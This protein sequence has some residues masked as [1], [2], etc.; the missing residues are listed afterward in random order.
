[1]A[2][3]HLFAAHPEHVVV[4]RHRCLHIRRDALV[5]GRSARLVRTLRADGGPGLPQTDAR[6]GRI[7][8]RRHPAV[9]VDIERSGLDLPAG[10]SDPR[11]GR[12]YF[13]HGEVDAPE[14][15][16]TLH[17]RLLAADTTDLA[18][19]QGGDEVVAHLAHVVVVV[20]PA[21]QAAVELLRPLLVGRD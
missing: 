3:V 2:H 7:L 9:L 10:R 1:L 19:V 8:D 13:V 20:P 6:A 14:R 21:E 15:R 18:A 16:V 12:I 11:T 4:E 5:P 17:A